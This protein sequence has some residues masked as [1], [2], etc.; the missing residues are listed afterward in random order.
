M[1]GGAAAVERCHHHTQKGRSN[2]VRQLEG[3]VAGSARWQHTAEDHPSPP[4]EYRERAGI[5]P[6]Q[7]VFWPNRST[8][9]TDTVQL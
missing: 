7:S 6:K 9:D 4:H 8:T 1:R 5:L 3:Y 2:R